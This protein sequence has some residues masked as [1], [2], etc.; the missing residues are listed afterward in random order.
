[1]TI[2]SEQLHW[3]LARPNEK[4]A[5]FVLNWRNDPITREMSFHSELRTW[6][7]FYPTYLSRY[8][9]MQDLP[10]LFVMYKGERVA[11]IFFEYC[12]HPINAKRRCCLLSINIPPESRSKGLGSLILKEVQSVVRERGYDT[13]LA[14]VKLENVASIKAFQNAGFI[15]LSEEEKFS[16]TVSLFGVE[17]T[18]NIVFPESVY[19]I[20]EAGSNWRLGNPKRDMA[21]AKALIDA[22]VEAQVDA[23]KFQVYRP[24]TIYVPNAGSSDY[25]QEAGIQE[26]ITDIFKDLAMP[27]E[28]IA[29]LAD[30]C[31]KCR[32]DFLA[33]SFSVADF[34]QID[35]YV[36]LHK[37]A[38]YEIGHP[39]LIE[40]AAASGKPLLLSTGAATEGEIAWAVDYFYSLGGSQLILLQCTAAYPTPNESLHL[41]AIP[42]LKERFRVQ[43]GLSDHSRDPLLAPVAATALG[44][45]V[46]EKHFTLHNA[47]PGPDH[48][49]AVTPDELKNMVAAVRS[50]YKM[51]GKRVKA[52]DPLE[53]EL[54]HYAKRG[55][56]AI[57]PIAKG[58]PLQ[59]GLNVDFLRPGKQKQG[60]PPR[61]LK[62]YEGKRLNK[63]ISL[64]SG[65]Q[66]EDLTNE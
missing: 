17:L 52:I 5:A 16:S 53:N 29:E 13:L 11:F 14:E 64:G 48:F 44:G 32:V 66:P 54:Q 57:R 10:P 61:F 45:V 63:A 42:W 51:L 62:D 28:M 1:M 59:E 31:N 37:I 65:I 20:A 60:M 19:I 24:E 21:M 15:L 56:Q 50:T 2:Q 8:F 41:A 35:P 18:P 40:K 34:E 23:V 30:Y 6:E 25:L 55:V 9:A 3:E 22:A 49:F 38:S 39:R 33:T 46:I 58:E 43:A 26:D 7:E 27:Y 47:I 36:K 4:D 12:N